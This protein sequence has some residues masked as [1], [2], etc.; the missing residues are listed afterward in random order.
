MINPLLFVCHL[1]MAVNRLMSHM[2]EHKWTACYIQISTREKILVGKETIFQSFK[3]VNMSS[4]EETL[5]IQTL[6]VPHLRSQFL[7]KL[8]AW[9]SSSKE[10]TVYRKYLKKMISLEV[11]FVSW[12]P[13]EDNTTVRRGE[14]SSYRWQEA[15]L[16]HHITVSMHTSLGLFTQRDEKRKEQP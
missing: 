3:P 7:G 16:L 1:V 12:H 13:K 10:T 15:T 2:N 4:A 9:S 8:N 6:Y 11:S 5:K 14:Y